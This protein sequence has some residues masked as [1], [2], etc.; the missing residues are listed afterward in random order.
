MTNEGYAKEKRSQ[1]GEG[2]SDVIVVEDPFLQQDFWRVNR[3]V[4]LFQWKLENR[5]NVLMPLATMTRGAG[6]REIRLLS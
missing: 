1:G 4:Q 6:C 3:G 2:K 5:L